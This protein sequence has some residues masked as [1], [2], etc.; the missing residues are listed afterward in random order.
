M[1]LIEAVEVGYFRSI[2]RQRL[3]KLRGVTVLFGRNDSG[4]SNFLRALNLFFR[5]ETNPGTSF[6]FDRDFCHDRLAEAGTKADARKFVSIRVEF[7]TPQSWQ[8]SLGERFWVKKT[9][10]VTRQAEPNVET[11]IRDSAKVQYVTRFLNKIRYHYV[12]AIKDRRIFEDLLGQIYTVVASEKDF[13]ASLAAFS[14]ELKDRTSPLTSGLSVELGLRSVIAPPTDLTDLFRSL[15]FETESEGGDQYSLT[16]Q[17]GDGLQ[18]RHIPT[19][20][21]F[22][23]DRTREDFHIW[24]FEEPENSLELANAIAEA[25]AFVKY[26]T[27]N[28]KQLFVTSHSPAFF[29]L[30]G[31]EV[32][33]WFVSKTPG[34]SRKAVSKLTRLVPGGEDPGDLMGETPHLPVI[35]RHLKRAHEEIEEWRQQRDALASVIDDG[36]RPKLFVEGLSDIT[37]FRA[38]WQAF[39]GGDPPFELETCRGTTRMSALA[40][41]GPVLSQLAP[42]R[43]V[44]VLV[45]NDREGRGLYKN[46]K[47]DGGGRWVAHGSNGTVWCR[48]PFPEHFKKVMEGLQVPRA[49]WPCTL[50]NLFPAELREAAVRE[51]AYSTA[52]EPHAE[53]LEPSVYK[54]IAKVVLDAAHP[55]RVYVMAPDPEKKDSFATWVAERSLADREVLGTLRPVMEGLRNLLHRGVR[56]EEAEVA[57]VT[58]P[59]SGPEVSTG[60]GKIVE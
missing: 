29:S 52:M 37:V 32:T 22:L 36:R 38:A 48:L 15:D 47:L 20:L 18:V 27:Q 2:Y 56:K 7:K 51:G 43:S 10:S 17:R 45:D 55:A 58:G 9:W 50:E 35:S 16:L 24:G 5:N 4:K 26:G 13:L 1:R 30:D 60:A 49:H 21:A 44:Y 19:I 33:R 46:G 42:S 40:A 12:P 23:S 54:R 41:D 11:S 39:V 59:D 3:D 25:E 53:L 8:Q 31:Q 14:Q 28:N 6:A 34:V 57:L